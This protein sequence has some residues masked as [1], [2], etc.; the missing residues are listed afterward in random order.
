MKKIGYIVGRFNPLHN[1]HIELIEKM[2]EE[3]D[4][5]IIFVGSS[6]ENNTYKNPY[7]FKERK[8]LLKNFFPNIIILPLPD[9]NND[10][11][12]ANDLNKKINKVFKK[13]NIN[14]IEEINMYT[15]SKDTDKDL[16]SDWLKGLN[17]GVK[18]K[19][20]ESNLSATLIRNLL[21]EDKLHEIEDI[22]H[23]HIFS[24]LQKNNRLIEIK[25]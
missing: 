4:F 12:W 2:I 18:A 10:V 17:H 14:E 8:R 22:L 9:R 11:L 16:R 6:N 21:L 15:G 3:N 20:L 1:G 23:I 13:F 19:K 5:S 7:T 24:F 25:T